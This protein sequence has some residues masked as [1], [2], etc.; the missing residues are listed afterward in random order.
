M[1]DI[2]ELIRQLQAGHAPAHP[3]LRPGT[4]ASNRQIGQ[5]MHVSRVTISKYRVWAVA[6]D[7]I[8]RPLASPEEVA[9]LLAEDQVAS[10]RCES[11]IVA[12]TVSRGGH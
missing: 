7:L 2:R 10:S 4:W 8:N 6:H 11:V 1:L 12:R 5:A 3:G 9:H